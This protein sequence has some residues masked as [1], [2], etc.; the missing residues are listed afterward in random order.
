MLYL[1]PIGLLFYFRKNNQQIQLQFIFNYDGNGV[2]KGGLGILYIDGAEVGR[3]RIEK[4]MPFVYSTSEG[5]DVGMD[6]ASNVSPKYSP[7]DN[8]FNGKI[9][10][11]KVK[12]I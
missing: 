9:E 3:G 5:A 12:L 6:K 10:K 1:L 7:Y 2:G 4:T 8:N 11:I